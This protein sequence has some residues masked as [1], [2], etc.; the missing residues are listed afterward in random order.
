M[1]IGIN[2]EGTLMPYNNVKAGERLVLYGGGKFGSTLHRFIEE[3]KLCEIISW[4]DR[5]ENISKGVESSIK[6]NDMA[7]ESYDKIVIAVLVKTVADQIQ[8]ELTAKGI[9]KDKMARINVT[10]KEITGRGEWKALF[11]E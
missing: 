10:D 4:I 9:E 3:E 1:I 2:T 5:A 8:E 7:K 11:G 6:L